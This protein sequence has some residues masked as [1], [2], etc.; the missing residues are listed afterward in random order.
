MQSSGPRTEPCD[1]QYKTNWRQDTT[2]QFLHCRF[3]WNR[4]LIYREFNKNGGGVVN[5]DNIKI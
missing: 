5:N 1:M 4:L 2:S 3:G